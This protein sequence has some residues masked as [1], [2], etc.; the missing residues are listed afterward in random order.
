MTAQAEQGTEEKGKKQRRILIF[1][2]FAAATLLVCIV[3]G[4][5]GLTQPA[6]EEE[7]EVVPE[8]P[9]ATIEVSEPTAAP[10]STDTPRPT[11]TPRPTNTPVPPTATP[12]ATPVWGTLDAP[13]PLGEE[14]HLSMRVR[15]IDNLSDFS[16]QVADVIRGDEANRIVYTANMFNDEPPQGTSWMLVK[17]IVTLNDGGPLVIDASDFAVVSGG[18]IFGGL[19]IQAVACCTEE[20]GYPELH[21]T[22][23]SPGT[24]VEGWIVRPVF[25]DDE[26]PLLALGI[27]PLYPDLSDGIYFALYR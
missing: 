7:I 12:T 15:V 4:I 8:T 3:C 18:Q 10:R 25:V 20:V 17:V 16:I 9:V 21:A 19:D 5:I 27:N 1:V 14:A 26:K 24:T 13:F 23:A 22:I 2:I 6:P 11:S